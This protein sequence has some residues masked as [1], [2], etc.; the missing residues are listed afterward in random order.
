[1][2]GAKLS[3]AIPRIEAAGMAQRDDRSRALARTR[4]GGRGACREAADLAARATLGED[5]LAQAAAGIA[6]PQR[7][8]LAALRDAHA[9]T[10]LRV[11]SLRRCNAVLA[12]QDSPLR[13][14]LARLLEEAEE[15]LRRLE[16]L[17]AWLGERPGGGLAPEGCAD[18][19]ATVAAAG[20]RR[21]ERLLS[22]LA[23]LERSGAEE[24]H[25]LRDLAWIAGQN[26]AATRPPGS[27]ATP[28]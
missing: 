11:V 3:G 8:L 9:E 7:R 20:P 18:L 1:M 13:P 6:L 10:C 22:A 28:T 21:D 19:V 15:Q 12:R 26:L 17:F 14:V 16:L 25:R 5:A 27:S 23:A 2:A 4:A 24:A